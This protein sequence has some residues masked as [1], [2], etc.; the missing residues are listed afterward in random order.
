MDEVSRLS[1]KV[2]HFNRPSVTTTQNSPETKIIKSRYNLRDRKPLNCGKSTANLDRLKKIK[3]KEM[4]GNKGRLKIVDFNPNDLEWKIKMNHGKRRGSGSVE[5]CTRPRLSSI[6]EEKENGSGSDAEAR[7]GR[8]P[9]KQLEILNNYSIHVQTRTCSCIN[10]DKGKKNKQPNVIRAPC[11][12]NRYF[13]EETAILNMNIESNTEHLESLHFKNTDTELEFEET[14]QRTF[15]RFP[16]P[17]QHQYERERATSLQTSGNETESERMEEN[18]PMSPLNSPLYDMPPPSTRAEKEAR[19]SKR[20]LQLEQWKRREERL[21]R[22]ERLRRRRDPTSYSITTEKS[23][24]VH[25]RTEIDDIYYF[26]TDS[27][28]KEC[29]SPFFSRDLVVLGT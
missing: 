8:S 15:T 7:R 29:L 5:I 23:T 9:T 1:E 25:W 28:S 26:D 16:F 3:D 24:K 27:E 12:R 6:S 10:I 20:R 11:Q 2:R 22:S 14:A 18:E 4:F 13:P 21:A 19:R 17:P